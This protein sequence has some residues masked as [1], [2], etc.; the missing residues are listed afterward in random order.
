MSRTVVSAL[1]A[2]GHFDRITTMNRTIPLKCVIDDSYHGWRT[3][4]FWAVLCRAL[5]QSERSVSSSNQL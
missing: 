5:P 4:G 1:S 2:L 3:M